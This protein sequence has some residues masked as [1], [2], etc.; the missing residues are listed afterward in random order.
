MS[1]NRIQP[2][3]EIGRLRVTENGEEFRVVDGDLI[4]EADSL[5]QTTEL[6]LVD[7]AVYQGDD[8]P[9]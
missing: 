1:L 3:G 7:G 6:S 5:H 8:Y 2:S 9:A 4:L